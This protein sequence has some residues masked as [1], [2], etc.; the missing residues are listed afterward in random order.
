[1][2]RFEY[3]LFV[4][5]HRCMGSGVLLQ[6]YFHNSVKIQHKWY[7]H[8]HLDEFGNDLS[9]VLGALRH[10]ST[11]DILLL[12]EEGDQPGDEGHTGCQVLVPG[13]EGALIVPCHWHIQ[14]FWSVVG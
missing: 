11:A 4:S 10:G 6:K 13:A 12:Q 5:F 8:A 3:F 9:A 2:N 7:R 14:G 1:M